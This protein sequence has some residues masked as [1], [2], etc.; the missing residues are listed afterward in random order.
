MGANDL[1]DFL[2]QYALQTPHA[3]V[4]VGT[5]LGAGASHIA[6][7][8]KE[9]GKDNPLHCYDIFRTTPAEKVKAKAQG[10]EL[11][12]LMDTSEMV[13]QNIDYGNLTLHKGDLMGAKWNGGEI[14]LFIDDAGKQKRYW[15]VKLRE[16]WPHFIRGHTIIVL[17]DYYFRKKDMGYCYEF[18]QSRDDLEILHDFK[19]DPL[20]IVVRLK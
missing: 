13:R 6:T 16:F 1:R 19:S 14:G 5:W 20:G 17:Q 18:V 12:E 4:E 7:A 15:D 3:I 2:A 8:L 9:N 10:L 11:M